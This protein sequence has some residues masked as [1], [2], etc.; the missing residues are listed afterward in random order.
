MNVRTACLDWHAVNFFTRAISGLLSFCLGLQYLLHIL[1]R[2]IENLVFPG[3]DSCEGEMGFDVWLQTQSLEL[4]SIGMPDALA[5]EV[6]GDCTWQGQECFNPQG[7]R[8]YT[9]EIHKVVRLR[10]G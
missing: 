10:T 5:A 1:D 6:D 8:G 2:F 4:A 7:Q 3:A 9:K